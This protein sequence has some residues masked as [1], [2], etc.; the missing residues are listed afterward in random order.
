M[1]NDGDSIISRE[2]I[3][4]VSMPIV[5][6]CISGAPSGVQVAEALAS[7]P[8]IVGTAEDPIFMHPLSKAAGTVGV[9]M[10]KGE[11]GKGE[12]KGNK[13]MHTEEAVAKAESGKG[14]KDEKLKRKSER[15]GKGK[16]AGQANKSKKDQSATREEIPDEQK[17]TA[18]RGKLEGKGEGHATETGKGGGKVL[19]KGDGEVSE[20]GKGAGKVLEKG[21]G[22]VSEG[23]V[24]Q[25]GDGKMEVRDP[26]EG[27]TSGK[28]EGKVQ[29]K[30]NGKMEVGEPGKAEGKNSTVEVI[31]PGKVEGQVEDEMDLDL[32]DPRKGEGKMMMKGQEGKGEG[33]VV[34]TG[35]GIDGV[36]N[37][38]KGKKGA[39]DMEGE[40]GKGGKNVLKKGHEKDQKGTSDEEFSVEQDEIPEGKGKGKMKPNV[41]NEAKGDGKRGF[42][43]G[44]TGS[45]LP[46]D[47]SEMEELWQAAYKKGMAKGREQERARPSRPR[48]ADDSPGTSRDRD[49]RRRRKT[50]HPRH[51]RSER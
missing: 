15:D 49:R 40:R 29:E 4:Q 28:G 20:R 33:K 41:D 16:G 9:M 2:Y 47:V 10:S 19:E 3:A 14:S 1:N 50:S 34:E 43:A 51:R 27:K 42:L 11:F 25:K 39:D 37:P 45:S 46:G 24:E 21:D 17:N 32:R 31:E 5:L 8:G 48:P 38:G 18:E 12:P 35:D 23:K 22:E 30:G 26:C 7:Q 36:S 13:K 44:C 6:A